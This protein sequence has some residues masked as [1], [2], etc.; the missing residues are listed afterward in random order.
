MRNEWKRI[1]ED[2][3]YEVGIC[4]NLNTMVQRCYIPTGNFKTG[5]QDEKPLEKKYPYDRKPFEHHYNEQRN[6]MKQ[7][8]QQMRQQGGQFPMQDN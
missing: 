8:Q 4:E 2:V 3:L 5:G 1:Q 6:Q 7:F